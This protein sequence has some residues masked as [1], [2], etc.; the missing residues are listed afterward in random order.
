MRVELAETALNRL[1][2]SQPAPRERHAHARVLRTD[3]VQTP[4][5][6][7][8]SGTPYGA[9]PPPLPPKPHHRPRL[10]GNLPRPSVDSL[11]SVSRP[12]MGMAS[13]DPPLLWRL[14]GPRAQKEEPRRVLSAPQRRPLLQMHASRGHV[15]PVPRVPPPWGG[16]GPVR[17]GL[18]RRRRPPQSA[19]VTGRARPVPP[20]TS[21]TG[22]GPEASGPRG[23]GRPG[24]R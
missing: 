14:R 19:G 2:P 12:S 11:K 5:D 6:A 10:G 3:E 16:R 7:T 23:Q 9:R 4:F 21:P 20:P 8:S 18:W 24:G 1:Q 15:L 13:A 22:E 17:R